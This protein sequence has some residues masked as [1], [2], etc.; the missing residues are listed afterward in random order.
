MRETGTAI[1]Q[2]TI[3]RSAL[4]AFGWTLVLVGIVGLFLPVVPGALLILAGGTILAPQSAWLRRAL[5]KGRVRA[6][7]LKRP[8]RYV[9]AWVG[10]RQNRFRNG[11]YN[12]PRDSGGASSTAQR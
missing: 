7:A 3:R 9:R 1:V 10:K 12:S 5:E 8:F 6:G 4:I 2:M 11:P